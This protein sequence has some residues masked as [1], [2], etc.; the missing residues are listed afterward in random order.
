MNFRISFVGKGHVRKVKAN[1]VH[2]FFNIEMLSLCG[3]NINSI[4]LIFT[5]CSYF[6]SLFLKQVKNC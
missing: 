1:T 5:F 6:D 2:A 4:P 3:K